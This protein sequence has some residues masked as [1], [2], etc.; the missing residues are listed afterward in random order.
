MAEI[1]IHWTGNPRLPLRTCCLL[2]IIFVRSIYERCPRANFPTMQQ[3]ELERWIDATK[4]SRKRQL[5]DTLESNC[6]RAKLDDPPRGRSRFRKTKSDGDLPERLDQSQPQPSAVAEGA[7]MAFPSPSS[8]QVGAMPPPPQ[9]P[10]RSSSRR[11]SDST[12]IAT[13]R[14]ASSNYR[15]GT[16]E[17]NRV[18]ITYLDC[19][20]DVNE[21]VNAIL[22]VPA[23]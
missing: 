10:S 14:A 12:S 5:D 16:L 18:F 7:D 13:R 22:G 1:E 9:P 20:L 3:D 19:P 4:T 8:S 2:H 17:P 6:K 11:R 21:K 15:G 23:T